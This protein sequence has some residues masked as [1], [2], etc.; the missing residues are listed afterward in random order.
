MQKSMHKV[1]KS[2]SRTILSRIQLT[3]HATRQT[4]HSA[5]RLVHAMSA[6]SAK[7]RCA[8][9][10]HI[11]GMRKVNGLKITAMRKMSTP[12]LA[13]SARP[14]RP[15]TFLLLPLLPRRLFLA[16]KFIIKNRRAQTN[17]APFYSPRPARLPGISQKAEFIRT[18][19]FVTPKQQYVPAGLLWVVLCC[20]VL[21]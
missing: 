11:I 14:P 6:W 21:S 3:R 4:L 16:T 19:M 8:P 20:T 15:T 7:T 10:R 1:W 5:S 2:A 18:W 12:P 13:H 17:R 9:F